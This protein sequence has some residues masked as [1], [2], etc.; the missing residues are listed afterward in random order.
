MATNQSP[1][2]SSV[3]TGLSSRVPG[4]EPSTEVRAPPGSS[5][6]SSKSAESARRA[7]AVASHS[8]SIMAATVACSWRRGISSS[9][10]GRRREGFTQST[11]SAGGATVAHSLPSTWKRS[12]IR[13]V[14]PGASRVRSF[15]E[16]RGSGRPSRTVRRFGAYIRVEVST[17]AIPPSTRTEGPRAMSPRTD[18]S[19]GPIRRTGA[20]SPDS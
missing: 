13:M 6:G 3:G 8:S 4:N 19:V 9:S 1:S 10:A 2:T 7:W 17:T 20:H 15:H 14:S 16:R 12:T 11:A 18:S 5:V